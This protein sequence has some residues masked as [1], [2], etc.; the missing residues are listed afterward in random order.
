MIGACHRSSPHIAELMHV[1]A[2]TGW[3]GVNLDAALGVRN[4]CR[5]QRPGGVMRLRER[6]GPRCPACHLGAAVT[7]QRLADDRLLPRAGYR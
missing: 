5:R 3:A 4:R 6:Q 1:R 7:G 2:S